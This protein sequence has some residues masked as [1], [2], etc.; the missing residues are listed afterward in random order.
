MLS[1]IRLIT[2]GLSIALCWAAPSLAEEAPLQND[3]N[4]AG[5]LETIEVRGRAQQL[6]RVGE[7]RTG[8]LPSDSLSSSLVI[9]SINE[10]LIADQG[11]R[12]A[13][14]LYRNI[15]GVSLFSYAG[16]TARGFR[17]EEIFY[18][19]VRGDPYI[20][21]N[22]PQL[23]N[24]ERVDFL[25]GPAGMLYGP[26]APGGLFNYVTKKPSQEFSARLAGVVG[27]E[28]R[29]GGS[30]E[31]TGPLNDL[32]SGRFGVFF[33]D[34][35][36]PR[37]HSEQDTGIVD[38]GLSFHLG[39]GDLV[40]QATRVEQD[41]PGS[42]LRGVP[43]DDQG[44]FLTDRRW[45]HNEPTDFLNLESSSYQIY[46]EGESGTL[47]YDAIA[48]WVDAEQEQQYH[49]PFFLYGAQGNVLFR[50][51][52][53]DTAEFVSRQWRDQFREQKSL[54]FAANLIWSH[55][56]DTFGNRLLAGIEY[57]DT[58]STLENNLAFPTGAAI[59]NF[60]AGN[61]QPDDI[62]PLSL[63]NP[64]Y[65]VSQPQNYNTFSLNFDDVVSERSGFYLLDELTVGKL[66]VI[67]GLRYDRFDSEEG[68]NSF[69]DNHA[70]YRAGLV[71]KVREDLSLF[72]HWADSYE[73][74]DILDQIPER[75]GPFDPT[76]GTVLEVGIKTELFAG[77]V[78]SSISVYQIIRDNVLQLSEEDADRDGQ[79]DFIALGEVESKGF[80]L[81]LAIDIT[82]DWVLT[83]AYAYN[84][85]RITK[86]IDDIV[87]G[88]ETSR[89]S[90]S[91][92][93]RFANAPLHQFGAWT[94]YQF[95]QWDLAFALGID[96]VDDRVNF[97]D[98][99]VPSYTVFDASIM[100]EPA[101]FSVLLRISNL[102]DKTYAESGFGL[103]SGHFPGDARSAFLEV[104]REW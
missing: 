40:L 80:E 66:S 91:V 68:D 51:D 28:S 89:F 25:K 69:D 13:Q 87:P 73:P 92:G 75:G 48:R 43:V 8:K 55:E 34:R 67:G 3:Q 45:N 58:E 71:Y 65:G 99:T 32:M 17:Q 70:T 31:I 27:D 35:D 1:H 83:A 24:V 74:Q 95:P 81:D 90:D 30:F 88:V 36:T 103:A 104:A 96:Y 6:Y 49:E 18:D 11:A 79:D 56:G 23:F 94:R 52:L 101:P 93:D 39:I 44:N 97:L 19:G 78:Q 42:R 26:G 100:W 2:Y 14:D 77:R 9:S 76:Q 86:A 37:D 53:V 61:S 102:T 5:A 85:T 82:D 10:Q 12:D 38:L 22:V 47:S 20:S 41:N 98:V 7:T 59:A 33:E 15:S 62:V 84:D 60:L 72:A 54:S 46:F 50:A 57:F 21:F 4:E 29:Y 63:R 64:V 16:V